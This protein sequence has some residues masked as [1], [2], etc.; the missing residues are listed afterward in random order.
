MDVT[1][2]FVEPEHP[3]NIGNIARVMKN[4]G[5]YKLILVNPQCEITE[6]A[7]IVA[8]HAKD[9]L[10]NA[11]ILE[12]L[13][14]ALKLFDLNIGTTG[15]FA[16]ETNVIRSVIPSDILPKLLSK[17]TGK[18]G[19]YIG[20]ESIGFTNEELKKFDIVVTIPTN[21]EYPIMNASHAAAV[22]LYELFKAVRNPV[23]ERIRIASRKEK[24]VIMSMIDKIVNKIPIQEYRKPIMK[25]VLWNVINK[26]ILTKKEASV[27]AGFF[28][29]ILEMISNTPSHH[30]QE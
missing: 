9:V 24:E 10:E 11:K 20:R 7:Y 17:Y 12:T 18:V 16:D 26:A 4:F 8:K 14:D 5:F 27:L 25:R 6:K 3:E 23:L 13:D 30:N 19:L 2:I 28:R 1:V 22:L 29:N 21:P 15:K